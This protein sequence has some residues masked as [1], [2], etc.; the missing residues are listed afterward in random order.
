MRFQA[1]GHHPLRHRQRI[2][3]HLSISIGARQITAWIMK[4]QSA[5][6]PRCIIER[7]AKCF[8]IRKTARHIIRRNGW[9]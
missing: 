7:L 3:S 5:L 4:V 8:E 1:I 6:P 9:G 2:G